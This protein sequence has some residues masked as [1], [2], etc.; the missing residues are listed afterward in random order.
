MNKKHYCPQCPLRRRYDNKPKSLLGRF[1]HWHISFCPDW[2]EYF[3]SLTEAEQN[4]LRSQYNF[5]KYY[6]LL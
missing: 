1:W 5:K 3:L 2:K 6:S 4:E